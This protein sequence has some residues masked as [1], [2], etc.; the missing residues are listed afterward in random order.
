MLVDVDDAGAGS[1]T[2]YYRGLVLLEGSFVQAIK[3]CQ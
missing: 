2:K 3:D 1:T